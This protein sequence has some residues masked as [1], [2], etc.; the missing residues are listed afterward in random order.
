MTRVFATRAVK[1]LPTFLVA[2]VVL[3]LVWWAVAAQGYPMREL[4]LNDTGIWISNNAG[5]EYGRINKAVS[6]LDARLSPPGERASSYE[7]DI[8]QDGNA[9][10]GW[11]ES[12]ATLTPVDT[13]TGK[14]IAEQG[15][16][17][18]AT[19][20]VQVRG[21]TVAVL[22]RTG[23]LWVRGYDALTGPAELS[24]MGGD[25]QPTADLGLADKDVKASLAVAADGTVY[26][27]DTR[28]RLLTIRADG[29]AYSV[30]ES[31]GW[32]GL[33]S[34]AITTV[35]Q[36]IVALDVTTGRLFLPDGKS[37][38]VAVDE[39]SRLQQPGPSADGVLLASAKALVWVGLASGQVS[40]I[41]GGGDGAPAAPVRLAGCDFGAWAGVGRVV[42]SCDGASAEV[43]QVDRTGG[44][45]RPVFRIN[46]SLILLNDQANGRA[47]DL[48]TQTSIDDW[49]QVTPKGSQSEQQE[50]QAEPSD[51]KPHAVD[52]DL[53]ARADR[54]T[55]LHLL[56]NDTD[57]AGGILSIQSLNTAGV[58]DG[59]DL[60]VSPDGQTVKLYLPDGVPL[61]RFGYTVSNGRVSDE[62][63][64]MV[65]D[66]G[67]QETAPYLLKTVTSSRYV[68][69]S[70]GTVSMAVLPNWRD[71]EGDPVSVVSASDQDGAAV[72]VT[73]DGIIDYAA[74][75]VA[76]DQVRTVNYRVSDGAGSEPRKAS[77][78]VRVLARKSTAAVAAVAEPDTARGQVG[79]PITV[80]PLANDLPGA[81]PR[82]LNAKLTVNGPVA[83]KANLSVTTDT[84]TGKV[85]V[86]ASREGP[87]FLSY[88]VAFGS[89]AVA[90]GTI[91][92]D[93]LRRGADGPVAM[94]DQATVRGQA[95]VL[96]DV[97]GNDYDPGGELLTVQSVT[98]A[99]PGQI[100]AQVISGRWVRILPKVGGLAPN[101][102]VLHYRITNGSQHADGDVLITQLPGLEAD[103][104]LA[105]NDSATV[106]VGDSTLI[107]VLGNDRSVSGQRLS[108]VTDGLGTDADGVLPIVDPAL[109]A[110]ADQGDVGVAYVH[111]DKVRYVAPATVAGNRQ[112]VVSYTAQTADGQTAQSQVLVTIRPEPNADD[113]DRAPSAASVETRVVAGSR[114]KIPIP[115]SGQDPDGDTVTVTGLNSA[116]ALGRVLGHSPNSITYEAYPTVG[117]VGTDSFDYVVS[118]KYGRTGVGTVQVAVTDPGQ[119]QAP[120]AIDDHFTAAPRT[121]VHANVLV[122]DYI[123]R[124]D[125]ANLA[126][127]A[128]VNSPVPDSVSAESEVGPITVTAPG[129]KAQPVVFNYALVGNGGTGPAATVTITSK[130]GFNNPPVASD[131]SAEVDGGKAT[132]SLLADAWDVEDG[133][134]N[135][136]VE[137]LAAVEGM[138]LVGD[139][140]T[141]PLTDHAQVIPYRIT[142][143][144][145]AVSAAV[146]YVPAAGAVGPQLKPNASI[147][148]DSDA[149][150]TFSIA[151]YVESPRTK[152]V[153][154]S[155]SDVGTSPGDDLAGSV[156][157]AQRFTL[158]SSNGYVGPASVTL[159]VMD[160]ESMTAEGVLTAV[161][162]IPV[163]V[164]APT[165]V[166]RCPEDP[167]TVVQGG[168]VKRLHI[169]SLCHVWTPGSVDPA[170]LT[171]TAEWATPIT[172]VSATA[173]REIV[174]LQAAGNAPDAGEGTVRIGIA[175]TAATVAELPVRV[176][177]ADPPQVRSVSLKDIMAGSPVTVPMLVSSPLLD[178]QPTVVKAVQVS[179][180]KASVTTSGASLSITPDADT[181]GTLVFQVTATDL[182]SDPNRQSRW[183]T[184]TVT[185][186]VY[187]TPE[188]PSRPQGGSVI[189]SH[190]AALT[191]AAG[192]ANGA[193]IDS[194]EV[195]IASGPGAGR[196]MT[197]RSTSAQV[198][199]LAN[200]KAVAF[201]V[202]A[203]NKA[204]WSPWSP[205]SASITPDT[206][207]GAPAWVKVSDP[208]DHSVLVSWGKIANDGSPLTA[209]H[210][211]SSGADRRV[212]AGQSSVRI[213]TPSNNESYS[214]TVAGENSYDIG[215]SVSARGQSSGKPSGL[216]VRAPQ[217]ATQVGAA[218]RVSVSWTLV[219]PEG[220]TPVSF[221]VVRS[222]GKKI[223]TTTATTCI[224][225]TVT[226]DGARY[227][228]TVTA[229]NATGGAAH[230]AAAAS[231]TLVATGTPDRWASW[232]AAPTGADGKVKLTYTV[233]A[234]RGASSA[235]TL[236][237][238][239]S[240][241]KTLT[242][243]GPAGGARTYTV[244]GQPDGTSNTFSLKVCNEAKRCSTSAGRSA[245]SF[246][247]LAKPKITSAT[248]SGNKISG[249]ATANGNG[250]KATLTLRIGGKVVDTASGSGSLKVAGSR[251]GLDYSTTY[252]VKATLTTSS[253]TPARSSPG[254]VVV[255]RKTSAPP[256]KSVHIWMSTS[257]HYADGTS[258]K[259]VYMTTS[260]FQ[261]TYR[262]RVYDS[263]GLYSNSIWLSKNVTGYAYFEQPWD[264]GALV[265]CD[266]VRSNWIY[267]M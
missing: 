139:E 51:A 78:K 222:D 42:R 106:R 238:G 129:I 145:G 162:S 49:P 93:A 74:G 173:E 115:T 101:P 195:K 59:V 127:L 205:R 34:I 252:E 244:T 5:G 200:G 138:T 199:G 242:S 267:Y 248:V 56:D 233:P 167:Q 239:G 95:P 241:Y 55:V 31:A 191:W 103:V 142:D 84:K 208:Q 26:V 89:A 96:I 210:V 189:Q 2:G 39:V 122:N 183:V 53:K 177:P 140:L 121:T 35:G 88:S 181:S 190:A 32:E 20:Q 132:A 265:E 40:T 130:E 156:D 18:D 224:D 165:P 80:F 232:S 43:Q 201:V 107:D 100:T 25:N 98:P 263:A 192:K 57:T 214:F 221:Q 36:A 112:V 83:Q 225:D 227:T 186:Q 45:I 168:E 172:G 37:V 19:G 159:E 151:D 22:D 206:A 3:S 23:K 220:P 50:A 216:V 133:N 215:P 72:A 251:S 66:A 144:G 117:M 157:D 109:P 134:D 102:Q 33:G 68:V 29:A 41:D 124:D 256:V 226:F 237:R 75:E 245:S 166:L 131:H 153:R 176:V 38:A 147:S 114:I 143:S 94:P 70:F 21:G 135:L 73:T 52:D 218:T 163:Q 217:P 231:P 85:Q 182:A 60:E 152:V 108:L 149:T 169:A 250:R 125:R 264:W 253:T 259:Q 123:A 97:L 243:P 150:A 258:W 71:A 9:V 194:Y 141:V 28:G 61:V 136:K 119:T 17:V 63:Q 209:I 198:T 223:C 128:R 13:A 262:C 65:R 77:V 148:I 48:D 81:D 188:A 228:Y 197:A 30:A 185:V 47:W 87:Y 184:G 154:I 6:G 146:V 229:T 260:G 91:R 203:H 261:G 58:P 120:V 27:A 90:K 207:P 10:L 14:P 247:P 12:G 249:V 7:L 180:G 137:T 255:S 1:L 160:A 193:A 164:G 161:I 113:P 158:T 118:D 105:N 170:S 54:T 204:G 213:S 99:K 86:V 24:G 202:R 126:D 219:S 62:G 11:D 187:S 196:T 104:V 254:S 67:S 174:A 4:D 110:D 79:E 69:T 266:G 155:S 179:G 8:L 234:S 44:L 230:S 240:P 15:M 64:V 236:L 235:L 211:T 46:H 175:G 257:F 82:N 116:P 246:G 171:Y 76:S 111:G 16:G 178:A 212:A 92:I